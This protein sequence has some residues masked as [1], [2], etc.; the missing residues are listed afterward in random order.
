VER[1]SALD[2]SLTLGD[3]HASRSALL[4]KGLSADEPV[5]YRS[6]GLK[7]VSSRTFVLIQVVKRVANMNC[8]WHMGLLSQKGLAKP[9]VSTEIDFC[10]RVLSHNLEECA[11]KKRRL[12]RACAG[13]FSANLHLSIGL[14][15]DFRNGLNTENDLWGYRFLLFES[16]I[17]LPRNHHGSQNS[18]IF[19]HG[20]KRSG[21]DHHEHRETI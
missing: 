14:I 7:C 19:S 18:Y 5:A 13:R 12:A 10:V 9:I 3:V 11:R 17:P 21:Y 2:A 20:R 8:L 15:S 6:R 16:A 1:S 4:R